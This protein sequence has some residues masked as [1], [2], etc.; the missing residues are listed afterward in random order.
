MMC[1]ALTALLTLP[2]GA[3]PAAPPTTATTTTLAV[4]AGGNAVTTVAA[5][6]VVALTATVTAGATSVRPAQVA[7]CDATATSCTG[8]HLL[9]IAQ[10]TG[11][12]TAIYRFV[13]GVGAH[14]YR[15]V[16][17]GIPGGTTTYG[18]SASATTAVMVTGTIATTTTIAQSGTAPNI[19]LKATTVGA[20]PYPAQ[21]PTQSVTINLGQSAQNYV[22]TGTGPSSGN[23][24][25]YGNYYNTQ[26]SC[27]TSGAT[28]TC[29]LTGS[30]TSSTA[31]Y[32]SGTYDFQTVF[33]GSITTS[34]T[35]QTVYPVGSQ[36]PNPFTY[37]A[38]APS[39][40]MA[41]KLI[42]DGGGAYTI[43]V[44]ENGNFAPNLDNVNFA[45]VA[46]A[47]AGLP[48]GDACQED[49]VGTVPGATYTGLVTG[50]VEFEMPVP[51]TLVGPTGTISFEDTS[52]AN[53]VLGTAALGA[54]TG[55]LG[56]GNA[57]TN[58]ASTGSSVG[59][60][61]DFNGDGKLDLVFTNRVA[62]T[63]T[64]LLGKGDGTFTTAPSVAV[65]AVP[66]AVALADFDGD[67]NLD[68]AVAN[69]GSNT[70]TILLGK[71][72]GTF[73]ALGTAPATGS[74]PAGI[75]AGDFNDDGIADLIVTNQ[76]DQT[77]TILL[78][79]G[80]GTFAGNEPFETT[81]T[82]GAIVAGD[83]NGD[84]K[85]D[86]A[87]AVTSGV[88]IYLGRGDGSFALSSS[89]A[90]TA[91]SVY[92][93]A[94]AD[95][96]NDGKLDLVAADDAGYPASTG[97]GGLFVLLGNGDGTFTAAAS[98]AVGANPTGVV[99]ADLN[100]DGMID[101]AVTNIGDS[102]AT[103][104]L[105]KGDGTFTAASTQTTGNAPTAI[106]AGDFNGDGYSDLVIASEGAESQ[107]GPAVSVLLAQLTQTAMA[108]AT[109]VAPAV[110]TH[111][112]VASYPGD[113]NFATSVSQPT[114]VVVG[115]GQTTPVITW[116]MPAAIT[117]TTPL[118]GTQLDATAATAGG[119]AIPGTF[120]YTPAAGTMLAAGTQT[121]S[122]TFT[123]TDTT[124]FT[125]ATK[126]TTIVVTQAAPVAGASTTT[127]AIT[128][129]TGAQGVVFTLTATVVSGGQPVTG[130]EVNFLDGEMVVAS[131]ELVSATGVATY[132][133]RSFT[134]GSHALTAMFTGTSA[135]AASAT[136][137]AVTLNVTGKYGTTTALTSTG[138]QGSYALTG[139]VD[140]LGLGSPT[141]NVVFTDTSTNATLGT[142]P[143]SGVV[144][145][146]V[147][148][149]PISAGSAAAQVVSADVNGDG[150]LDLV[151]ANSSGAMVTVL[152]GNGDGTYTA[153]APFG[154]NYTGITGVAVADFNGDGKLDVATANQ[155]TVGIFL[156]NGD[157]TFGAE[158]DF[159]NT[160]TSAGVFAGDFNGDG[161]LDLAVPDRYNGMTIL[162]GNG[163]GT[164]T[165]PNP[166]FNVGA[167]PNY[168]SAIADFNGDGKLDIAAGNFF[169]NTVSILIGN[170]DGTFQPPVTYAT[171]SAPT[172]T[173]AGDFNGDGITD[174]FLS[175]SNDGTISVL[176]GN[177][178]G[179]FK[180]QQTYA[181]GANPNDASVG[182]LNGDGKLD[183]A[184]ANVN[185][186]T[187]SIL[188][189]NGDGTFKPQQVL[190]SGSE[191]E[192]VTI[193][194]ANGDGSR[195]VE[196]VN[197]G[198]NTVTVFLNEATA[199]VSLTGVTLPGTGTD[200][201]VATYGGDT[202]FTGSRSNTLALPS[203]VT[204][205]AAV[206]SWKPA[207]G[208]I[209][210]GTALGA[211]QLNAT[212]AT[213]A[214][215]AIPG[216]FVYTPA[217]GAVLAAGTQ[218]LSVTFTPTSAA[219]AAATG[220]TTIL[221]TKAT[222]VISWAAPAM[223]A[224]G[225]PLSATQ[226]D[227]TVS[228]VAAGSGAGALAGT[229]VYTPPAGT[230]LMP[231]TQTLS[232][233]FAPTDAVDYTGAT[234]S[235]NIVVGGLG[236]SGIAPL[237][238]VL[239]SANTT[240][241]L[242]GTGFVPTSVVL[243][244]T[245]RLATKYVNGTTLT[246][247]V[248]ATLLGATGPLAITVNDP[249]IAAVSAAQTFTVLPVVPAAT[250][251]GPATTAPGTQPTV[252]LTITNPYP[253]ALTA[254]FTLTFASAGSTPV[255]DPSIQF[256]TGGRMYSYAVAANSTSVP[257]VQLQAGTDAG[258]ITIAATLMADG[259]DVTPTGLAPLVIVVPPVVPVISGTTITA[260][261]NTLT[262]VVHG[263]SNTREVS[264]A[265]FDF[266]A[267]TGDT[268]ATPSLT[269][270]ATTIFTTWYSDATSDA[271]GS[272]FTYT[273][274]FNTSGDAKTVGTVKVTLTNSVGVSAVSTSAGT[275]P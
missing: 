211:Q 263:F 83:F 120:V 25:T 249:A 88:N 156:G 180:P 1:G 84:G 64:V 204:A 74:A 107:A 223:I 123:P 48:Q 52:N 259:V 89:T 210:Y 235:V 133:T 16:F 197:A 109:G 177:G 240:I 146:F 12:G 186:G 213:A 163:D 51:P 55:A 188:F 174:I 196:A 245:N 132:K 56:F 127:L 101:L 220:T 241:T 175:N 63:L 207:V 262:V 264:Q 236:L 168:H 231:G 105:G 206:I 26:G 152:L 100:G 94:V 80:D 78:G 49:T 172:T 148:G 219:Y 153:M 126:T 173:F 93:L 116:A 190:V 268:V 178:D 11:S 22:L 18:A 256:S 189:G 183:I 199:A 99:A 28:T 250:L 58:A 115:S 218:T 140:G 202:S 34:I 248:P 162:I 170:G 87:I 13:P 225:T 136:T 119:T 73:T 150:K 117:T 85:L 66:A 62:G 39:L 169:D 71:G 216:T 137:A 68:I 24:G 96:N 247:V 2:A 50:V 275:G 254:Q 166:A 253:L 193:G 187:V 167:S 151:V 69:Q 212:A 128:P 255:D 111:Q 106:K 118:S 228:G 221:V 232:V 82:P 8:P 171:G 273:Q 121:L 237:G 257:P 227:A 77:V 14:S 154:T 149:T 36:E 234:A 161:K 246:A 122:V 145:G 61:G 108:T 27:V 194:D 138:V 142:V 38:F 15:A 113:G 229:L 266:T 37:S 9:G 92:S 130:G 272:T 31:G 47:C 54:A 29:D 238:A 139:T 6:T 59:T 181:V 269:I 143:V 86:L 192:S 75:V 233:A 114:A 129:V 124:D 260:S 274:I 10:V 17:L 72:N 3:A 158:H 33:T 258:T 164:F 44:A 214:G 222:P 242:T 90:T 53:A 102:T 195:D 217:A 32:A 81:N 265:V 198:G 209:A 67:G 79:N 184:V 215:V 261:G 103:V 243:A 5:G 271:Y 191:T 35:S 19:T 97:N 244:G 104:L 267:E 91:V 200:N 179:T 40:T 41:L 70:V 43:P 144:R 65:G 159:A 131:A 135:A 185:D 239:G 134:I 7:F 176:L 224:Y 157:G 42:V 203:N 23:G 30:F 252:G 208:T 251:T 205:T 98:P 4:V 20:G 46:P 147:P 270:P 57:S 45:D 165:Q 226:L 125:T 141:G 60:P 95:L 110:G 155:S 182:D 160:N 230:V 21:N 112:V 76:N 201:V